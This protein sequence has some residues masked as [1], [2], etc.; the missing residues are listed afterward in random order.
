[1][2]AIA[3][4]ILE[5]KEILKVAGVTFRNSDGEPR[6]NI[7]KNFGEDSYLT[8]NLRKETYFNPETNMP[9]LAIACIEKNTKKQI[10]YIHRSDIDPEILK[11]RQLTG[12]VGLYEDVYY[13]E[14]ARQQAP[15]SEMYNSIKKICEAKCLQI[16]AY[17]V[18]AYIQFSEQLKL[19][20]SD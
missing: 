1:M 9:E 12:L 3:K 13:C 15:D 20:R 17:D 4:G 5:T 8:I 6:Q 7:L 10:G 18:R 2:C 16:P 11:L 19:I 14:L